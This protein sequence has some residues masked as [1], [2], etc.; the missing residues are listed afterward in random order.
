[1]STVF[2]RL[3]LA[4]FLW[5]LAS[6]AAAD[7]SIREAS[8]RF[9]DGVYFVDAFIDFEFSDTALEALENGVPLTLV[10]EVR[11]QREGGWF[12]NRNLVS[13]KLRYEIRYH[14]L[15]GLYEIVDP[16]TGIQERFATRQAAMA[17]LGELHS[18]EVA[19]SEELQEKRQ[20]RV[21]LR[22]FLDIESL[23]LPL[24]PL[25]YISPQWHLG[26]GW[27]KWRLDR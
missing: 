18:I 9:E 17:K 12:W 15:S 20:H 8:S 24:R 26:T 5:A 2:A 11:I 3:V 21:A 25:A 27:K 10:V 7:F 14:A 4:G 6:P 23:P 1:M 16:E 13:R 19:R 22:A